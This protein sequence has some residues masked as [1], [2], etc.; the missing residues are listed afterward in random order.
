[1]QNALAII[2]AATKRGAL[3]FAASNIVD[4]APLYRAEATV[5]EV[6]PAD[7]H[8]LKGKLVAKK[9]TCDKIGDAAGVSFIAAQCG[10]RTETLDDD[11]GRRTV[12]IGFAQGRVRLS[13]GSFRDS[14]VEEYEF[15]PVLRAK[16]DAGSKP[17]AALRLDYM[18]CARQR[19]STG[20]RLRVIRQLTGMPTA[21]ESGKIGDRT[22]FVFSRVVLNTDQILATPEGRRM[23]TAAALGILPGLYGPQSAPA[24]QAPEPLGEEAE[25]EPR[26][27]TPGRDP[28]GDDIEPDADPEIE[29]LQASL[30]DYIAAGCLKELGRKSCQDALDR[31]ETDPI[32]LRDLVAKA[33]A[34]YEA[35][36]GQ[37]AA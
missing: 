6:S 7:F 17:E 3:T 9:E 19:A 36:K 8:N 32:I 21:F 11:F 30:H 5:I 31:G 23:A 12:Y 15:D 13:D 14:A 2:E 34:A 16:M 10:V 27:V 22:S 20:A 1:M 37:G 33:K 4:V 18:R 25:D 28:F 26:N 29:R 35:R 24:A